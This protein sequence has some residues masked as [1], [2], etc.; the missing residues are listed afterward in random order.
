MTIGVPI[1]C[2][3][4]S[5]LPETLQDGGE[6]F[7]PQDPTTIAEAL[8]RLIQDPEKRARVAARAKELAAQYSWARC[9][10]ETWQFIVQT[11][12]AQSLKAV[13]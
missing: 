1:A 9:A 13:A 6:Y 12:R 7:N 8:N 3:N 5:S 2:S 11:Y 10:Q 4:R